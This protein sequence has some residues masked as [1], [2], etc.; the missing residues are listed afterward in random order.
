MQRTFTE[1]RQ[2]GDTLD[3][4]IGATSVRVTSPARPPVPFGITFEA[5]MPVTTFV[6]AWHAS[7]IN[8]RSQSWRD[9]AAYLSPVRNLSR[10]AA[11][12][13]IR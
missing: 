8:G 6:I 5:L 3:D 11:E 13:D 1:S 2:N 12:P 4:N 10:D 7:V 9:E